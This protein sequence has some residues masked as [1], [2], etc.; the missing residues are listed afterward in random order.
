VPI[1][2][3]TSCFIE[4]FPL[5]IRKYYFLRHGL[6]FH[7]GAVGMTFIFLPTKKKKKGVLAVIKKSACLIFSAT[8][9]CEISQ[10]GKK[11]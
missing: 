7:F 2:D 11:F 3:P 1:F 6:Q 9:L 10:F 8:G 5:P 4:L